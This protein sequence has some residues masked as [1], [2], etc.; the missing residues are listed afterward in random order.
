MERKRLEGQTALFG[1]PSER[2]RFIWKSW[3]VLRET[4]RLSMERAPAT[5][6]VYNAVG[7]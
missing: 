7:A 4:H 3:F 5:P 6:Y 2:L 1:S